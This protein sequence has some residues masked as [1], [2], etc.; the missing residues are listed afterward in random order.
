M[1]Q[2]FALQYIWWR[3]AT[4]QGARHHHGGGGSEVAVVTPGVGAAAAV[5][6][7]GGRK[8]ALPFPKGLEVD[9]Y[10]GNVVTE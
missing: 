6:E 2:Q 3:G 10:L 8:K 5:A 4:L 7:V 1:G 9:D